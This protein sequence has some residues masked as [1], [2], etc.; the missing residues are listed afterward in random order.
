M[1]IGGGGRCAPAVVDVVARRRAVALVVS[2]AMTS[3]VSA[4]STCNCGA[5]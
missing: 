3:A 1:T 2:A 5:R 4:V